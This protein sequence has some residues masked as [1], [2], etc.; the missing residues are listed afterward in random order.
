VFIVIV[1]F[2]IKTEHIAS[3][4]E[5]MCENA[6]LSTELEAGCLH[7][8]VCVDPAKP[9]EFFLY[10]V[11]T[12]KEAFDGHLNSEHFLRFNEKVTQWVNEKRVKTLLRIQPA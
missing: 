4:T 3:F 6:A 12:S 7:F 2:V 8:D 9:N 1:D 11:Y 5:A 10:E